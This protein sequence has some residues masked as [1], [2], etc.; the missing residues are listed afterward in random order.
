MLD[1]DVRKFYDTLNHA[2]LRGFIR[3]RVGDGVILRLVDKWLKAGVMEDGGV[4]YPE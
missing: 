1:V 2:H 4:V 3:R